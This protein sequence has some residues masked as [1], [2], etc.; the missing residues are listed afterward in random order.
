MNTA[1]NAFPPS[2]FELFIRASHLQLCYA[3][4]N[5]LE[6]WLDLEPHYEST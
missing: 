2:L 3:D 5:C 1:A 4:L 6:D